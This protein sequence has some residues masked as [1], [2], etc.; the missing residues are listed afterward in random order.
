MKRHSIFAALV[1]AI[2]A[3][4]SANAQ[5]LKPVTADQVREFIAKDDAAGLAELL[6]NAEIVGELTEAERTKGIT[7]I[8]YHLIEIG[9]E[10][11]M[12]FMRAGRGILVLQAG[13]APASASPPI[14]TATSKATAATPQSALPAKLLGALDAGNGQELFDTLTPDDIGKMTDAQ[15]LRAEEL[16]QAHV[17]PMPASNIEGNLKGYSLLVRLAPTNATYSQKVAQY[18]AAL[19]KKRNSLL[20]RMQREKDEFND[21]VFISHPKEPRYTN[22]RSYLVTYIADTGMIPIMRMRLNYTDD[23]WLFI[24]SAKANIDGDIVDLKLTDWDRDNNHDIWEYSDIIVDERMRDILVR[25][26]NSKKTVIRFDGRQYYDNF[27]IGNTDK[28]IIRDMFMVEE[29]LKS[30]R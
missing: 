1:F 22:S 18:E 2:L 11:P 4:T 13:K 17:R 3:L 24:Q 19:E 12:E 23:S 21:L 8:S 26:A 9:S 5:D 16:I 7:M 29:I 27:T 15:R 20:D 30:K 25:I 28:E 14:E 6:V 10:K